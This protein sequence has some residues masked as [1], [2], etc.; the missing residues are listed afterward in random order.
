MNLILPVIFP[1][2]SA[3]VPIGNIIPSLEPI[4]NDDNGL[5]VKIPMLPELYVKFE[6]VSVHKPSIVKF[7]K[8]SETDIELV[9]NST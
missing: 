1:V 8:L 2:L 4:C 6:F 5:L 7:S 9:P 3:F